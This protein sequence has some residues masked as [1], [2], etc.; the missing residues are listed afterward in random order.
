MVKCKAFILGLTCI[1]L[2]SACATTDNTPAVDKSSAIAA[3]EK[4]VENETLD[5]KE[6]CKRIAI[7]GT[8]FKQ[9]I[10]HTA[11]EWDAMKENAQKTADGLVNQTTVNDGASGTQ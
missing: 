6:V 3:G 2:T 10:C 7:T 9:K 5:K 11:E 8:R 4:T 1:A